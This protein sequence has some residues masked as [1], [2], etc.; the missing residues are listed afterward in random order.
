M[1]ARSEKTL[2]LFLFQWN[3]RALYEHSRRRIKEI[4][5]TKRMLSMTSRITIIV[6]TDSVI[7]LGIEII[8]STDEKEREK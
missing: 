1:H 5:S 4:S 6:A 2:F 3:N 8:H 7:H